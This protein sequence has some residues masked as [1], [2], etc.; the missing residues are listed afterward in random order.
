MCSVDILRV[1]LGIAVGIFVE[2]ET[3]L[4][5]L[6]SKLADDIGSSHGGDGA[7]L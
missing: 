2:G 3:K 7:R 6:S 4:F 1:D 5:Q